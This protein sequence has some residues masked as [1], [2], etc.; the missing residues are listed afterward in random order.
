[1]MINPLT[2][3]KLISEVSMNN[4]YQYVMQL[5]KKDLEIFKSILTILKDN[6][7][8]NIYEYLNKEIDS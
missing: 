6:P 2:A 4:F 5:K 1:M 3:L 7:N 8:A